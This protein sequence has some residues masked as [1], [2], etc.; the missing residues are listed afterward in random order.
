MVDYYNNCF[1]ITQLEST[2]SATVIQHIN[3][4]V[5]SNNSLVLFGRVPSFFFHNL[6]IGEFAHKT[7]SPTYPESNGFAKRTVQAVKNLLTKAKASN[8]DPYF[9]IYELHYIEE[10]SISTDRFSTPTINESQN[11]PTD[12]LFSKPAQ[13]QGDGEIR[14]KTVL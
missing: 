14:T 8:Q 10:H 3:S 13:T 2:K 5:I 7:S 1:E 12:C 6:R 11:R 9:S 4:M